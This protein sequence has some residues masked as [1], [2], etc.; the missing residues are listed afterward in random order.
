MSTIKI[1]VISAGVP[2]YSFNGFFKPELGERINW[3]FASISGTVTD[4]NLDSHER[5]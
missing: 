5:S 1:N 4:V 3:S 2:P